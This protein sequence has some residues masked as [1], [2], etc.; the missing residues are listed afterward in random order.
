MH[1]NNRVPFAVYADFEEYN[2]TMDEDNNV[3]KGAFAEQLPYACGFY[4]HSVYPELIQSVYSAQYEEDVVLKF[5]KYLLNLSARGMKI[6]KET[7]IPLVMTDQ[8]E[9]DFEK[10]TTCYYCE[11][12]L[13]NLTVG[14]AN[15]PDP[16]TQTVEKGLSAETR[17]RD[18]DHLNGQYRC[19]AHSKSNLQ[20]RKIDFIPIY[21]HNGSKYDI[22]LIFEQ[23]VECF[24]ER[25]VTPRILQSLMKNI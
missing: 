12:E 17:V 4:V 22:H 8:Q 10:A 15:I 2:K 1:Y 19:A 21:F 18:H 25:G 7:D 5:V 9:E 20:A 23:L 16:H 24:I 13:T 6:F 11:R 3:C 14:I